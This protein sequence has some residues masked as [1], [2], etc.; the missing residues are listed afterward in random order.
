MYFLMCMSLKIMDSIELFYTL[1]YSYVF[2]L[3]FI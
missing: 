2:S 1:R 3:K